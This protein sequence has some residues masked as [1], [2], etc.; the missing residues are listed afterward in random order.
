MFNTISPAAAE[1]TGEMLVSCIDFHLNILYAD[2][3]QF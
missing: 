2:N 1:D 3:D